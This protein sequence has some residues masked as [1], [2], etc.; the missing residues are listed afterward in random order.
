MSKELLCT[1]CMLLV[2]NSLFAGANAEGMTGTDR[3]MYLSSIGYVIPEEEIRIEAY[4]A[5]SEYNYTYPADDVMNL[6]PMAETVDGKTF[7]QLGIMGQKV[8]YSELPPMNLCFVIDKSGSM[9]ERDKMEWVKD[10]F[11]IFIE[12]VRPKD[13]VSLVYFDTEAHMIL[14]ATY[15]KTYQEKELF[16]NKVRA[17][18]PGGGT[19]VYAG[20]GIAYAEIMK[21]YNK[22]GVNRV[23][24]LTDGQHNSGEHGKQDI[25]EVVESYNKN[26]DIQI[27]TIALGASADV[28]LMV[29]MAINGGGSSRFISNHEKMVE[30][31]GSEIDRLLI[32]AARKLSFTLTPM[33]G[34]EL[35]DTWGYNYYIEENK[36][37]YTIDSLHNGDYETILAEVALAK[38]YTSNTK[39]NSELQI[40]VFSCEYTS[41]YGND[42]LVSKT[43]PVYLKTSPATL[44]PTV[45]NAAA[46][47]HLAQE[48]ISISRKVKPIVDLQ[49][50]LNEMIYTIDSADITEDSR[51]SWNDR[52]KIVND[53]RTQ[54]YNEL[55]GIIKQVSDLKVYLHKVDDYIEGEQFKDDYKIL[56][57]YVTTFT[58]SRDAFAEE[59]TLEEKPEN[60]FTTLEEE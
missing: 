33:E 2:G 14:P 3:G 12:N 23:I 7:I 55:D 48:L 50:Q 25:L 11:E 41:P 56:E 15:I 24:F 53:F 6:I 37:T 28:N 9:S 1:L 29:D 19:N 31:F 51:E 43:L 34:V 5:Q 27:S 4:I 35:V 45:V 32:P 39:L 21:N 60:N 46:Y 59:L 16:R 17:A 49:N 8:P 52:L 22:E 57:N 26:A 36:V 58:T 20:L 18:E 44:N 40:A 30:T 13:V 38:D 10:S 47:V 42:K 54:M